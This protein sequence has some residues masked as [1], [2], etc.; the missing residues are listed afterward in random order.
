VALGGATEA[1][2]WSNAFPVARVDPAWRSV[3]YGFPLRN[4]CYRVVDGRGRDCP[5]WVPGELWIGGVGV[6]RGYR[7]DPQRTKRRFVQHEGRPWYRTGD[8]GRYWTDGTLEFLGRADLQVK[9]R[10]HRIELGEIEAALEAHPDVARAAVTALGGPSRR[11]AAAVVARGTASLDPAALRAFVAGRLPAYMIPAEVVVLDALAL[12]ANGKLDRT[13]LAALI[14]RA[15]SG[16][17]EAEAP[18]GPVETAVAG[19]WTALL[20]VPSV[21]RHQSFFSLGGDSLVATRLVEALRV[22][23][24]VEVPLRQFFV[25]ATVAELAALVGDGAALSAGDV[26]EGV[27]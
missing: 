22:R 7:G 11:L 24:G 21:G 27:L 16:T 15:A 4:Q 26:E 3:P 12:S 9:I 23:F 18:D 1:A 5:D 25:A 2:I 19:I 10:G 20:G 17:G 6:A 8:L 14:E 13:A